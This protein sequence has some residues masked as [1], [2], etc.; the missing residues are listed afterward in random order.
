M[1]VNKMAEAVFGT[2][3]AYVASALDPL[4]V[5]LDQLEERAPE[6]GEPGPQGSAG[7][8]GPAGAPGMDGSPGTDGPPGR[9]GRDGFPG[10][11]GENGRDGKDGLGFDDLSVEHD[12]ER[13]LTIKFQRGDVVKSFEITLPIVIDRGVFV[14]TKTYEKGDGVTWSGS[15]WIA[16]KQT[17]EKPGLN[18]DWRLSVKEGRPGKAG[19]DGKD[20][21]PPVPVRLPK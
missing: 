2:V 11:A 3:K 8:R 10:A 1:D 15:F 21:R 17:S 12:G 19:L 4:L 7:E 16:Q 6:K 5:R 9:D 14:A 20:L 13:G 18:T